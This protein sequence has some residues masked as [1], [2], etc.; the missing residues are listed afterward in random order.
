LLYAFGGTIFAVPF[1]PARTEVLGSPVPVVE[2][3]RR[4]LTG[5]PSGVAQFSVSRTGTLVYVPGPI[6]VANESVML[7]TADRS[8][9]E[10]RLPAQPGPYVHVRASPDGARLAVGSDDGKE[11]IVWIYDLAGTSAMRRLTIGGHNRFPIWSPDGQRVAFQSDREG[12]AAIFVQRADGTGPV[13]RLTKPASGETH[14]PESWSPDGKVLLFSAEKGLAYTL[15]RLSIGDK[16]SARFGRVESAEP[17]GATFSPDGRWVAYASS[18]AGGGVVTANRGVFVQP[19]PPTG[20]VFQAPLQRL[21]YH[22]MW[23]HNGTELL[24]IPTAA[25]GQIAVVGVRATPTLSFGT[26]SSVPARVTGRQPSSTKRIHDILPDGRFV[27]VLSASGSDSSD[28]NQLRVV[29]NW[30]EELKARVPTK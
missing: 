27:G 24:Y 9:V 29:L 21:D 14:I 12:D 10:T 15:W 1:D 6:T 13:Q 8:G 23:G 5:N 30:T 4:A 3:V 28:R 2:G 26:V 16:D 20:D 17:T 19:Y 25:S 22:P 11:A 7:G 18:P